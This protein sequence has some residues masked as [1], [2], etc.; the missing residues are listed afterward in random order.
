MRN[1]RKR[2]DSAPLLEYRSSSVWIGHSRRSL[3]AW[4]N[5]VR[6]GLPYFPRLLQCSWVGHFHREERMGLSHEMGQNPGNP[7]R[8]HSARRGK[9][10]GLGRTLRFHGLLRSETNGRENGFLRL[11]WPLHD[12]L[13]GN[14]W[15][16]PELG[17]GSRHNLLHFLFRRLEG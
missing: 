8:L 9:C 2:L 4:S 10:S 17:R 15:N 5:P 7:S 13:L 3:S 12:R 6:H 1:L 16:R 14:P 11:F